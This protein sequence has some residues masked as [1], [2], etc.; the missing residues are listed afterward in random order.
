MEC[1]CD[2]AK[3]KKILEG[4]GTVVKVNVHKFKASL[5]Y[6]ERAHQRQRDRDRQMA[7]WGYG[8]VRGK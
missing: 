8:R 5:D 1:I 4:M 2:T 3:P 7:E 6:K